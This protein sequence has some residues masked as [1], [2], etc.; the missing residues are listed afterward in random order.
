[1]NHRLMLISVVLLISSIG[2]RA[3]TNPPSA[4]VPEAVLN[5]QKIFLGNAGETDNQ[6][7]LRATTSSM[8]A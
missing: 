7:G 1:M 4:P 8:R 2:L 6:D 5:A 3:Q